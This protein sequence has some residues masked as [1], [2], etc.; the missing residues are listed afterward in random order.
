LKN[1]SCGARIGEASARDEP[2]TELQPRR[3]FARRGIAVDAPLVRGEEIEQRALAG[4]M[5]ATLDAAAI[6]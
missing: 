1:G 3:W 4:K 2:E 5:D 6:L